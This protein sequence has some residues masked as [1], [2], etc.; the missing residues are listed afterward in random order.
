[1][2]NRWPH[3]RYSFN[4]RPVVY[5]GIN[6]WSFNWESIGKDAEMYL[7]GQ[8]DP[9]IVPI[10]KIRHQGRSLFF[11]AYEIMPDYWLF[12][13]KD[14]PFDSEGCTAKPTPEPPRLS[15]Y[16]GYREKSRSQCS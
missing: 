8:S 9:I 1:M 6:L 11:A 16:D 14:D 2:S 13:A 3:F 7:P 15:Y 10:Y 12:A 4:R 5:H